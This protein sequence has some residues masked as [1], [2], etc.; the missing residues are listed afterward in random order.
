MPSSMP[1]LLIF[2]ILLPYVCFSCVPLYTAAGDTQIVVLNSTITT[3]H[4]K[5][6]T[7]FN[8][9]T[10]FQLNY[11]PLANCTD[12][13]F[14]V[15]VGDATHG[16]V[17]PDKSSNNATFFGSAGAS[18]FT[19]SWSGVDNYALGVASLSDCSGAAIYSP[20]GAC[21][22][23]CPGQSQCSSLGCVCIDR[24]YGLYCNI[25]GECDPFGPANSCTI[26]GGNGRGNQTCD[27]I[28]SGNTK[29]GTCIL[30][31]CLR[32]IPLGNHCLLNSTTSGTSTRGSSTSTTSG[33][34]N[35]DPTPI[36]EQA[37]NI[38][39]IVF[40]GGGGLVLILVAI[41]SVRRYKTIQLYRRVN[42]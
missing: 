26:D 21:P 17:C 6:S 28:N 18:N 3:F 41:L 37:R 12:P 10:T 39:F 1:H 24:W 14:A 11:A 33:N 4:T 31:E 13:T 22:P 42:Y 15:Y 9:G 35:E 38:A 36:N 32:G 40:V 20:V 23:A 19:L 30:I 27:Y 34:A 8:L 5:I 16:L 25:T 7:Y 2:V 29:W